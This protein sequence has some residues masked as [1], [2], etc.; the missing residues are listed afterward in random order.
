MTK[1]TIVLDADNG[2][3]D[4]AAKKSANEVRKIADEAKKVNGHFETMGKSLIQRVAGLSAMVAVVRQIGDEIQKN[5][6]RATGASASSGDRAL[7]LGASLRSL[8]MASAPNGIEAAMNR[9]SMRAGVKSEDEI[10]GFLGSL[11]SDNES[12]RVKMS[13]GDVDDSVT[14][15][16]SGLFSDR[17]IRSASELPGGVRSLLGEMKGREAGL[18]DRERKER[19][20]R[21]LLNGIQQDVESVSASRGAASR[22]TQAR[23]GLA[24]AENPIASGI[25]GVAEAP[26]RL[27]GAGGLVDAGKEQ[28]FMKMNNSLD[29]I[30]ENTK[31]APRPTMSPVTEGGP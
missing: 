10:S 8:G 29:Q 5:R 23:I 6:D 19:S 21:G 3:V 16:S 17:E 14:A 28:I 13:T 20:T 11:A 26:F 2:K 24:E 30:A 25:L 18:T 22:I 4:A 12:R 7:S 27:V 1:Q 15:F 9:V 31:S